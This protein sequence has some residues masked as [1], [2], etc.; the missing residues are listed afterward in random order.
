M[1][2]HPS[3]EDRRLVGRGS[4]DSAPLVSNAQSLRLP[5]DV[6]ALK[7]SYRRPICPGIRS[8]DSGPSGPSVGPATP[9]RGPHTVG[10]LIARILSVG[11]VGPTRR[12]RRDGAGVTVTENSRPAP[13][14]EPKPRP[15]QLKL[16]RN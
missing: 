16:G 3:I 4:P 5:A 13:S 15:A 12:I 1:R 14:Q 2:S 9:A 11:V 10:A 6:E 7:A 8:V